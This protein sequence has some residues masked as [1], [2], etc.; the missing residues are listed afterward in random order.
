M[1][2]KLEMRLLGATHDLTPSEDEDDH[3]VLRGSTRGEGGSRRHKA[4]VGLFDPLIISTAAACD[5]LRGTLALTPPSNL[6]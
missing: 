1:A 4:V 5:V 2:W 6:H 3:P